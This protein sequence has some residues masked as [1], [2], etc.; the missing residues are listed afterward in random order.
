VLAPERRASASGHVFDRLLSVLLVEM[1]GIVQSS[2]GNSHVF[3]IAT[4]SDKD[5]LD[6]AVVRPGYDVLNLLVD[7]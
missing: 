4:T 1:D 6:P 5:V 3:I 7:V 2:S